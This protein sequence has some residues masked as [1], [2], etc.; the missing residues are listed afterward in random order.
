MRSWGED[1]L[2]FEVTIIV[3]TT[4]MN[5]SPIV[6]VVRQVLAESLTHHV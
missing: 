6:E 4:F 5:I 1:I 2:D 3:V